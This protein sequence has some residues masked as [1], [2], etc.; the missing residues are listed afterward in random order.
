MADGFEGKVIADSY[1]VGE[2]IAGGPTGDLYRGRHVLMD[3]SE[4]LK[5]LS[6]ELAADNRNSQS[7][8]RAG[9]RGG[10]NIARQRARPDGFRLQDTDG[11]P[12][13]VFEG[14][15]VES[16]KSL[17][18]RAGRLSAASANDVARHAAAALRRPT[19]RASS[20]AD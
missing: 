2:S 9:T 20:M 8:F 3:K 14:V 10:E 5:L 11:T 7:F 6:R 15:S 19:T 12:Y 13:A 17:L 1:E 18:E 4:M 16:L